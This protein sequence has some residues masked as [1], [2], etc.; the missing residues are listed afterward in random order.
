[1]AENI[2][3]SEGKR[4]NWR[5]ACEILGC[6]RTRFYQLVNSG[7]LRAFRLGVGKRNLWV[8]K[9]DCEALINRINN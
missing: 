2:Q 7:Q 5:Q 4:L 8:Y 3:E 1:M 9:E 6:K